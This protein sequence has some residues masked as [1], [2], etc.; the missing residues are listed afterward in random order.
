MQ[1]CVMSHGDCKLYVTPLTLELSWFKT[2]TTTGDTLIE[3]YN[4]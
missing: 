2:T 4:N 1:I 3:S